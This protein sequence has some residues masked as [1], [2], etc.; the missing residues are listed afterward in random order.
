M[1]GPAIRN[2]RF[3]P[4]LD[5][6]AEQGT[7]IYATAD[8]VVEFADSVSKKKSIRGWR[9]GNSVVVNHQYGY[10]TIYAHCDGLNVQKGDDV[11]RGDLIAWVGST[12]RSTGPHLHYEVLLDGKPIDPAQIVPGFTSA[13]H[14][15]RSD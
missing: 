8:G 12:G 7:P 11:T 2:R 3:P 9:Y 5:L 15:E 4:G 13:V 14:R 1:A 6:I 10:T